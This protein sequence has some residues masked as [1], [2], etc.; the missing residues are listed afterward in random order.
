MKKTQLQRILAAGLSAVLLLTAPMKA[1]AAAG[2]SATKAAAFP[3]YDIGNAFQG[4]A[5]NITPGEPLTDVT[6]EEARAF[7]R[8]LAA[9]TLETGT[10]QTDFEKKAMQKAQSLV[11]LYKGNSVQYA[12][13]Q[14]GELLL[15]GAVGID[16]PKKRSKVTTDSI[17]CVASI[18]KMFTTTAVM[19]L[20][21]AKKIDLD[22]PV[23][24]YVPE[25]TMADARYKDITVRMLLN[26]SSGILGGEL[27]SA[28]LYGDSDTSYHDNLLKK[29]AGE[30]LK[31]D[32]GA[33]SVYCNDG[34][35][36]AEIVVEHVSGK[37]F[38]EYLQENVFD[39]LNLTSTRTAVQV[40]DKDPVAGAYATKKSAKLPIEY[41]NGIGTGGIYSTAED[42]C[43]FGMTFTKNQGKVLSKDSVAATMVQEGRKGQWCE[44]YS[45][46][47][48]YGL[49]WDSVDTYPFADYGI[50]AVEKGGDSLNYHG[51]LV[52][53]PE[54]NLSVAVLSSGLSSTHD[55]LMAQYLAK[56]LLKE[57]G[58]ITEEKM[59]AVTSKYTVD[60]QSVPDELKT[61]EGYYTTMGAGYQIKLT[62][63]GLT[64]TA[65]GQPDSK[66]KFTYSGDGL[67]VYAGG[68]QAVKF[69]TQNGI[70]YAML[71]AYNSLPGI[72]TS[73][74]YTYFGQKTASKKLAKSVKQAWQK[75]DDKAYLIVSEK[76][77]S[78][79][80]EMAGVAMGVDMD[81]C[82][83][84]YFFHD[85]IKDA[86]NAVEFIDIPMQMSRDARNF[87]FKKDADGAEYLTSG[88]MRW[89]CEDDIKNLSAKSSFS[90]KLNA[91]T[92]EAKWRKITKKTAGKTMSVKLPK[93]K[94]CTVA[95][96]DKDGK[97]KLNS[98]VSGKTSVKLPKDGYVVFAGD[99]GAGFTVKIK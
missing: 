6:E 29:L 58:T 30:H 4:P 51:E 20:V 50:T 15:G 99:K 32:P 36:L 78:A 77:S 25:F 68:V 22:A 64:M 18:S 57:Q 41:F 12:V 67:F 24:T 91:K 83:P 97:L 34:F 60:K 2:V 46:M 95:V 45:G 19:Q 38:T 86:N 69:M 21:E 82:Q 11:S 71:G 94:G 7:E 84:G 62:G 66:M 73:Y 8:R 54:Q 96:Y 37:S 42:L 48:D 55:A 90:V 56:E 74:A 79:Y 88:K 16:D 5:A 1:D 26:H 93:N 87:T 40:T 61:Y 39:P 43:R 23:T 47:L 33:Y 14:N 89:I 59:N 52:V 63:S 49:G 75:R 72:G 13:M 9:Q 92:G 98:Y 65:I 10:E 27:N 17:Y 28:L 81:M 53:L 85:R 76:Y 3:A 70:K 44:E 80:Y 35:I 31:A